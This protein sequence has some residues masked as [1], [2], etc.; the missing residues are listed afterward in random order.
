MCPLLPGDEELPNE[1]GAAVRSVDQVALLS[2]TAELDSATA[3]TPALP[4]VETVSGN[5]TVLTGDA[6]FNLG[7][8]RFWPPG[9]TVLR[10]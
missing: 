10:S 6:T 7:G 9:A 3:A 8:H 4:I 5:D 1:Y 2:T